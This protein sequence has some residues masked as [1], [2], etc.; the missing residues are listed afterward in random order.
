MVR[1]TNPAMTEFLQAARQV[2]LASFQG[3]GWDDNEGLQVVC[4]TWAELTVLTIAPRM[5]RR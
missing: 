4:K 3:L 2:A 5:Q 1:S